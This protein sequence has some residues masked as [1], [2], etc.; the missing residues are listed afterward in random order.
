M[1]YNKNSGY[2]QLVGQLPFSGSGK[3]FVVGD[4][5]TANRQMLQDIFD[6]DVD[7]VVRFFATIDA[8][9]GAC[10]ANAGDKVFVMPGHTEALSDATSLNLDV[11]G[12]SVI[13]LGAGSDRPTITLDT[14]TS[15]T[16]P[17][18][19]A[20]VSV[21]NMIFTANF[22]DIVSVFTLTAGPNFTLKNCYIKSTA[23]LMNFL[24]VVTTSA[25]AA[26]EDGLTIEGCKWIEPDTATLSMVSVLEDVSDVVIKDNFV[27]L[28]VQNNTAALMIVADGKS[29]FNLQMTDNIVYRLNTDT[30]TGAIL[31]HTNQS[32]NSGI[33]ARNFAQHADTASELLI[34]ATSG[35]GTF[36]NFASGVAGASGY[37]LPARDS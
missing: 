12:V 35:L 18:T 6:V 22:A 29:A 5:G 26:A 9:I 14:A 16:V 3:V 34:T 4:S 10:T 23:S 7:G 25:V 17:V 21:E 24:T 13:G 19:A 2:G 37:V 30:A 33:V 36:E 28:G 20:N 8:A 15:A 32:D 11:E 31:F 1:N 27:Q